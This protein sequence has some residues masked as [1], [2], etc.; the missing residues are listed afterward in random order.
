MLAVL[1]RYMDQMTF[2][3]PKPNYSVI[4]DYLSEEL[5]LQEEG[6]VYGGFDKHHPKYKG[7]AC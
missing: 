7:L 5:D 4:Q 6:I 2:K 1:F 3:R